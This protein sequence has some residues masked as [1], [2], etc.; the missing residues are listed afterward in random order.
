MLVD[1]YKIE[2]MSPDNSFLWWMFDIESLSY[3]RKLTWDW[4]MQFS[5]DARNW[6]AN[7]DLIRPYNRVILYRNFEEWYTPIFSWFIQDFEM[8]NQLVKVNCPSILQIMQTRLINNHDYINKNA[9]VIISELLTEINWIEDSWF[10]FGNNNIDMDIYY[11]T[12]EQPFWAVIKDIAD[13]TKNDIYVEW[14]A[15]TR[16]FEINCG[17]I[18]NT[19]TTPFIYDSDIPETSTLDKFKLNFDGKKLIN[20]VLWT[21][22]DFSHAEEIDNW[23]PLL[24]KVKSFSNISTLAT[25]QTAVQREVAEYGSLIIYPKIEN[26]TG[27]EFFKDFWI[28]DLIHLKIKNY[29]YQ[30]E[31][32]FRINN[33]SIKVGKNLEESVSLWI[34][35][36]GW[37]QEDFIGYIKRIDN[38]VSNLYFK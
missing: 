33:V 21:T 8:D 30:I 4:R 22:N 6:Q 28:G 16:K 14:N 36:W 24:E 27:Y 31:D 10:I 23:F 26:L 2:V 3:D 5:M 20:K 34:S 37:E 19:K 17:F 7:N 11:D 13:I 35:N 38:K 29:N 18:G 12:K 15:T 25:L 32:D 9:G 1:L